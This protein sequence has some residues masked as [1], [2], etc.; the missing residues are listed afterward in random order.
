MPQKEVYFPEQLCYPFAEARKVAVERMRT[1]AP[2]KLAPVIP[3]FA[4]PLAAEAGE[5]DAVDAVVVAPLAAPPRFKITF[6]RMLNYGTTPGCIASDE[7]SRDKPHTYEC[8][9]RFRQLREADGTI[10]IHSTTVEGVEAP[11]DFL[12]VDTVVAE[13]LASDVANVHPEA[14]SHLR[15]LTQQPSI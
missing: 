14:N 7:F 4:L 6:T 1:V 10:A 8:R 13:P 15:S 5:E 2:P 12:S 3:P 11:G 9:A